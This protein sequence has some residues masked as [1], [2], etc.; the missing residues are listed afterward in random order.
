MAF[1]NQPGGSTVLTDNPF[2]QVQQ[3]DWFYEAGGYLSVDGTAITSPPNVY[4]ARYYDGM[5]GGISPCATAFIVNGGNGYDEIYLSYTHKTQA[6]FEQHPAG[7][8]KQAFVFTQDGPTK[9]QMYTGMHGPQSTTYGFTLGL[10]WNTD[11]THLPNSYW[12]G[13][14]EN[15]Y[16][17]G[18]YVPYV[19][20]N[21]YEIEIYLRKSTTPTARNGIITWWVNNTLGGHYANVNM[22][23]EPLAVECQYSPTWGGNGQFKTG[24]QYCWLDHYR[25]AYPGGGG[26]LPSPPAAPTNLRFV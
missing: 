2:N 24:T 12:T 4:T 3:S 16:L 11:N 5:P 26:P 6:G 9:G 19:P 18:N 8:T 10:E 20:G 21:W 23:V 25:I 7:F 13:P 15:M 14:Y 17:F 1:A 22:A